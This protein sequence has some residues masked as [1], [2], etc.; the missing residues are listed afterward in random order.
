MHAKFE[1][2]DQ[3]GI[4]MRGQ[5]VE[6]KKVVMNEVGCA[7][8]L[9]CLRFACL[10]SRGERYGS[11]SWN[12]SVM[13]KG[14]S[15]AT[16]A[17]ARSA[18]IVGAG[19]VKKIGAF[20]WKIR[21]KQEVNIEY[22]RGAFETGIVGAAANEGR[23]EFVRD[24]VCA[25]KGIIETKPRVE[26]KEV[27][28]ICVAEKI[29]TSEQKVKG[30]RKGVNIKGDQEAREIEK[31]RAVSEE[32][33]AVFGS[34]RHGQNRRNRIVRT[35]I[36]FVVDKMCLLKNTVGTEPKVEMG[37]NQSVKDLEFVE[38]MFQGEKL[39]EEGPERLPC[40]KGDRVELDGTQGKSKVVALDESRAWEILADE[41][42]IATENFGIEEGR[43]WDP[44]ARNWKIEKFIKETL[45]IGS[46]KLK[47]EVAR[48]QDQLGNDRKKV[49]DAEMD[50]SLETGEAKVDVKDGYMN[51]KHRWY[52]AKG[53][54]HGGAWCR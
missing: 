28:V 25:L 49:E 41:I 37:T 40:I 15:G 54:F 34:G 27:D 24:R 42:G 8:I 26:V 1:N 9:M 17:W 6:R 2:G 13:R 29:Y 5:E 16:M 11:R 31:V 38:M 14:R 45:K 4:E 20:V 48:A 44:G 30:E 22:D 36:G 53:G 39:T 52:C 12:T 47:K 46:G 43:E 23:A 33:R 32:R 10:G 35:G 7:D 19:I 21:G 50:L 51:N 18:K 3:H